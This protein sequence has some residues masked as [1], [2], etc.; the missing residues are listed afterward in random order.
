MIHIDYAELIRIFWITFIKPFWW[1]W[2]IAIGI[3]LLPR[4]FDYLAKWLEKKRVKKWLKEHKTLEEWKKVDGRKFEEIV[5]IIFEKLGYKTKIRV[6][7]GIDIIAE[8]DGKKTFVQCK[9]MERVIPND[10]RAFWGSITDLI[11]KREG[12]RG[13]F[14]TTGSFTEESKE[15]VKDKPIELVDGL[16][17]ENLARS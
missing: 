5:A 15:F 8:K 10:V 2:I 17:L 14:V 9:R 16:K 3:G 4:G 7:R 13:I 11:K 6:D 12:E 1:V